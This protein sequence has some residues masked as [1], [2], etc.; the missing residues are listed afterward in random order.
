MSDNNLTVEDLV[1]NDYFRKWV[2]GRLPE[3]DTYWET[4][5]AEAPERAGLVSQAKF[6]IEAF[7]MEHEVLGERRI[8]ENVRKIMTGV[9]KENGREKHSF[10]SYGWKV[11]AMIALAAAMFWYF[12]RENGH[13][14]YDTMVEAGGMKTIEKINNARN[15]LTVS[16]SDGSSITLQPGSRLSYPEEFDRDKREVILSGEGF[17]DIA[18]DPERPFRVYANEIVARVL[19]TSFHI[20][21]YEHDADIRVKV[22][23]GKVSVLASKA[24]TK[25]HDGAPAEGLILT[26]NQMAIYARTPE[27]LTRTLVDNPGIIK[28]S[29]KKSS[30]YNF[31]DTPV[32]QVFRA[33]E[34][35][36]GVPIVYNADQ[37]AGCTVTAPLENEN[38]YEKLDMICKV[39]RASYEIV[40]AQVVITSKGCL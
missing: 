38:L 14:P 23:S 37:L 3:E 15:P 17:F 33:L 6:I 31:E 2:Q 13:T 18:R 40:D 29:A 19:G 12:A 28:S 11:A 24:L 25:T 26:P 27:K 30:D 35:G 1:L 10:V 9:E 22:V 34:E 36:Y 16:L 21:A 5:L 39:I 7:R 20:R 32:P 8:K 4:W